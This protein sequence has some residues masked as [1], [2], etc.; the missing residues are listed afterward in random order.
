MRSDGKTVCLPAIRGRGLMDARR[1]DAVL[2]GPFGIPRPEGPV[3]L[4]EDIDLVL[5]PG[6]AFDRACY[7]LG[8]GGGYY[9][10]YLPGCRGLAVGLAYECQMVAALLL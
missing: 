7:R 4:P 3:I 2:P 10:R 5:V 8:Q 6:L 9:D 1:M